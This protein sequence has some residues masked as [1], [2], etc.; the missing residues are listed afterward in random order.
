M[1]Q[2][3]VI[4]F[5]CLLL[6]FAPRSVA[7]NWEW[8]RSADFTKAY[9]VPSA[10]QGW[11]VATDKWGSAYVALWNSADTL[12]LGAY[13]FHSQLYKK[14]VVV[15]K[16]DHEGNLVWALASTNGNAAP[17]DITT[18]KDGNLFLFGYFTGDSIRFGSQVIARSSTTVNNTCF[19]VKFSK[20]GEIIWTAKAG[21]IANGTGRQSF[22]SIAADNTG[23][24]YVTANFNNTSL[25]FGS[26]SISNSGYDDISVAK[27]SPSGAVLW[28][29]RFGSTGYDRP[30]GIEVSR[31]NK[32]YITGEFNSPTIVFGNTT[33]TYN[34]SYTPAGPEHTNVFVVQ[35]AT[36][37][38]AVWA[39]QSTGDT[40]AMSIAADTTGDIYVG[41]MIA[42]TVAAIGSGSF[43][44]IPNTPFMAKFNALGDVIRTQVFSQTIGSQITD[45]AIWG[46]AIDPCNNVWV[47]GGMDTSFGNGVYLDTSIVMPSPQ[48]S[49][50]PL[51]IACYDP[52]GALMDYS[53]LVSGGKDNSGIATDIYGNLFVCG[54]YIAMDPFVIGYDTL[55]TNAN[56]TSTYFITKYKPA[57]YCNPSSVRA[58]A[59]A[60]RLQVFP[61]PAN[62]T[63]SI[64]APEKIEHITLHNV[65][66]REVYSSN[67]N[68]VKAEVNISALPPGMYIIRVN[69]KYISKFIRE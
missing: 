69:D 7:Q 37:G 50:D 15:A 56:V 16:Y 60:A 58:T 61:N 64:T 51:F 62:T 57:A 63:I 35:L 31:D 46:I 18:D 65:M 13:N 55:Y 49:V 40:K 32:I 45:H 33:L 41:G 67:N 3:L 21:G 53:A 22:G 68:A 42:D 52:S 9:S 54:D 39:K 25:T 29:K 20:D 34:A 23:N 26:Y 47:T 48:G 24:V 27:F 12:T 4:V 10:N 28:A 8:A 17:I 2:T 44:K 11:P 6:F 14:Q 59:T 30:F 38:T 5:C 19:I 43:T 1:K 36:D 66:G